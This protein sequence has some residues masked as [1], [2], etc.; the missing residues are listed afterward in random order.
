MRKG[1]FAVLLLVICPI[2][3]AQA[4]NNDSVVKMVKAGLSD[5]VIVTTINSSAG[6]YDASPD[7]LIAL[8]QAG[9]SDKVIAAIVNKVTASAPA[10]FAPSAAPTLPAGVESIGAYHRDGNGNWQML[11]DEVVVFQSGGLIKH[12]ATAGLVKEDLNGLIGGMRSRLVV[13]SP[14][15][16]ILHT[17]GGRSPSDYQLL[18]L[19]VVGNNRQFQSVSGG[20]ERETGGAP[21]DDIEFTSREIAPS[22]FQIVLSADIGEGEFGFLEP[23]DTASQKTPPSSGKIF[24]FAIVE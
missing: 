7:A 9:V 4:M 16:F 24:T 8:K 11:P 14:V 5:D 18:R 23:Q 2:L 19:H 21:R 10:A 22:T 20:L 13:T 15:I 12:V 6:T 17:P 3:A 1:F